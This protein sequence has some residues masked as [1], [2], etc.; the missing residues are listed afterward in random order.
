MI[1]VYIAPRC[2]GKAIC[3]ETTEKKKLNCCLLVNPH[4]W[5]C[6]EA[7]EISWK[8]YTT[9]RIRWLGWQWRGDPAHKNYYA[10]LSR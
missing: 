3:F 5:R 10:S 2:F 9:Q 7:D 6:Q 8:A 1:A 4:S